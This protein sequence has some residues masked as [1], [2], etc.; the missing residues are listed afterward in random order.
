MPAERISMRNIREILRLHLGLGLKKRQIGRSCG[1]SHSTIGKYLQ[2]AKDAGLSWPLPEDL[3]DRTLEEMLNAPEASRK[4]LHPRPLLAM[5]EIH[6]ELRKKG[7]TLQLLWLEYK[8]RYPDGYQYTQ[9]CEYYNRWEK[10]L[11][12]SLRQ[13]HRAGEKM[14]IDF[15]G[16]RVPIQDPETGEIS[17]AEI[18]VAV[19][20]ASNYTYAEALP[21][22]SLPY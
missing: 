4:P 1:L 2:K 17:D 14:F 3:D 19:L 7:V 5:D 20:G 22:Q 11:E 9:F 10:T 13:E 16:Q 15:A 18:F 6:R 8:E 21:S 12:I